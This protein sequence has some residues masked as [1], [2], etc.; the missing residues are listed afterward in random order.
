MKILLLI[1]CLTSFGLSAQIQKNNQQ[2]NDYKYTKDFDQ[3]VL[4]AKR[5]FNGTSDFVVG[6]ISPPAYFIPGIICYSTP[7]KDRRFINIQNPNNDYLF[8]NSDYYQGYRYGATK[9]KR[10]RLMEGSLT[11]LG[12]GV[13]LIIFALSSLAI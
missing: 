3:G 12:I 9:K 11:T 13:T 8:S 6:L 7:P 1:V 4:D 5:H 2:F 10:K